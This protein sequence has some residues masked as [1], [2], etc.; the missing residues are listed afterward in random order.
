MMPRRKASVPLTETR[1]VIRAYKLEGI[2]V[3]TRLDPYGVIVFEPARS[4][5]GKSDPGDL[6][7]DL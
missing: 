4:D 5:A 3:R 6:A 2:D 7:E 1:R